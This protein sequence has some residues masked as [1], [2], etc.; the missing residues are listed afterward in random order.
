[1]YG[2]DATGPSGI[3]TEGFARAPVRAHVD[4]ADPVLRSACGGFERAGVVWSDEAEVR[5]LNETEML[6]LAISP[7]CTAP[8]S[9]GGRGQRLPHVLATC[10]PTA[11]DVGRKATEGTM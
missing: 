7:G 4:G 8:V 2:N 5:R 9:I 1:M 11:C 6:A 10:E 3:Q